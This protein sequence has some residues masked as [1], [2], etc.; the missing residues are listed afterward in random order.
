MVGATKSFIRSPFVKKSIILG[1][2]GS[3]LAV[4]VLV[5][6]LFYIDKNYPTLDI[7]TDIELTTIVLVGVLALGILIT[8]I[9]THFATQRFL[10]LRTDD[11]Y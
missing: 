6:S 7:F 8:W 4:A 2:I 11:L 1:A 3:F 10:N 9:S 5:G